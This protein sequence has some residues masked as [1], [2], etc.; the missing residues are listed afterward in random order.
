MSIAADNIDRW[1]IVDTLREGGGTRARVLKVKLGDRDAVLKDHAGCDP[2]FSM[3]LGPI[4][5][6]R[7]SKALRCLSSVDGVPLLIGRR[8]SRALLMEWFSA[9]PFKTLQR[10]TE[11]WKRYFIVLEQ[12]LAAIHQSGVAHCDLRSLNNVLVNEGG[13][14]FIV[15]FV[16]CC[17]KGRRWNLL[18]RVVFRRFCRADRD[19]VLKLKQQVA[20]ELLSDEQR[21]RLK[22]IGWFA[23]GARNTGK[24][25]RRLSRILLTR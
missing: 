2:L 21:N 20:P 19:A 18:S 13:E 11:F 25:I 5:A 10:D 16:A 24:L 22:H 1:T 6:R 3:L 8:G 12:T 14:V 23:R 15:D 7:E 9:V 17:F 4:L